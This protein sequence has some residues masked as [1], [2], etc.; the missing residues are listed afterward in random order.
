MTTSHPPELWLQ[1]IRDELMLSGIQEALV[2]IK[3][4][5]EKAV[6]DYIGGFVV[7]AITLYLFYRA[8]GPLSSRSVG[9]LLSVCRRQ[10]G[11]VRGGDRF[12]EG[13]I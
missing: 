5:F 11:Q 8:L 7:M 2:N 13:G 3:A 6:D 9:P 12:S 10:N 4:L 1:W